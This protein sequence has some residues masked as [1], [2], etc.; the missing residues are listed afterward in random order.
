MRPRTKQVREQKRKEAEVR[1]AAY[2]SLTLEQ[3]L[4]RQKPDGKV[5]RK[6]QYKA[7][8]EATAAAKKK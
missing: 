2:A 8:V 4:A 1:N 5:A 6:L 7:L 3:K